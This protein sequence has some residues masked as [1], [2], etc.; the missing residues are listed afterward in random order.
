MA[1]AHRTNVLVTSCLK[2]PV[3]PRTKV[4]L[5]SYERVRVLP[6]AATDQRDNRDYEKVKT[7]LSLQTRQADFQKKELKVRKPTLLRF[8]FIL[9]LSFK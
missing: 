6:R 3:D 7:Q 8:E 5:A 2:T 9:V 1:E 4:P